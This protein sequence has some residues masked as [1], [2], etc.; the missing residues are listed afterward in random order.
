MQQLYY[1]HADKLTLIRFLSTL[2]FLAFL[3]GQTL[4]QNSF[5]II[6]K[7]ED[8]EPEAL[9]GVAAVVLGS[10]NVA[11][12]DSTGL[13]ALKNIPDGEQVIQ[14]SYVGYFR[15]KLKVKFP[16]PDTAKPME[17]R[18]QS[19]AQEVK[20]VTVS[21][22][23]N[24]Q[25]PEY[26]PTQV[27]VMDEDEVEE[28]SHDKPSDVSH[29]LKEQTGF[30]LQR[31]SAI[32][33]TFGIRLQ[34][35]SSDYTQILQDG[36][37][38]F[39]GLTND[40]GI[41]QLPTQDLQQ[42]EIIKGP[43]STLYGGDAIA[44]VINLATKQPTETPVYDLMFNGESAN[45]YDAGLYA[46]Q[47][48][49]WFAFSITGAYRYQHE[50]DWSGDGYSETPYLQRYSVNPQLYFDLSKHAELNIGGNYTHEYRVGGTDAYFAGTAD[51]T[52]DY[53]EK[54]LTTHIG[55]NVR[56]TYDFGEKGLLTIKS[57]VNSFQRSLDLPYYLF[58]GTQI[59]SYSEI[60]YHYPHKKHDLVAGVDFKTDQFNE[61]HDSATVLRNYSYL[62]GGVF[63]QYMYHLDE[64]TTFEGGLR[65]DYNNVYHVYPLPRIAALER[66]NDIFSTRFNL[67]MGYKLPTIFQDESEEMR[68]QYVNPI[69]PGVEPEISLGGT[70]DLV[71]KLP[72]YNGLS[73][74]INQLY[75]LTHIFRP[76]MGDTSEIANCPNCIQLNYSNVSGDVESDGIETGITMAYRGFEGSIKYAYTDSHNDLNGVRGITP[77][78]SRHI[79]TFLAG[80]E[81]KNFFIGVDAYYYSPVKLSDGSTSHNI[82]EVGVSAQYSFKYFLLFANLENIA[83]IRQTSYGPV[84]YPNPTFA[85]PAFAEIY[86]PLEGRLFNAGVKLHLGAFFKKKETESEKKDN[87]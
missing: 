34:G 10:E 78:S 74:T 31:T 42:I 65:L 29:I 37:P 9:E 58:A 69:A 56:F 30:Q 49:K 82:W 51:S 14:I 53:Y 15:K 4:A 24:Y 84:V 73:V 68:F 75:F 85:H 25:K 70:V 86:G 16:L 6:V 23:R 66:W 43:S 47:K 44:G 55:S 59:A 39:S 7:S 19:Q 13:V 33:G 77:L 20:E 67:G 52:N 41:T 54:N 32:M 11:I 5:T 18:L 38:L 72:N 27:D 22:T 71:V 45:A 76:I 40:I 17:I 36:F 21:T 1:F 61:G 28:E 81:I 63:V 79:V 57:A 8:N 83:N 62:T 60:S 35:L 87:D 48:I 12:S 46:S 80:Y 3:G 26:L 2:L 64:K 50:K